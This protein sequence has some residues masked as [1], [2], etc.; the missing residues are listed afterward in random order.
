MVIADDLLNQE[1]SRTIGS[2][3][4]VEAWLH[5]SLLS[6]RKSGTGRAIVIGTAWHHDDLY[7]NLKRQGGW[8]VCHVPLLAESERVHATITY[9]D[10]FDGDIL[11]EPVGNPD[12]PDLLAS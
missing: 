6:R 10:D 5:Q 3:A 11:G 12:L 7:A 4:F 2:R 9:P 8:T 1:N